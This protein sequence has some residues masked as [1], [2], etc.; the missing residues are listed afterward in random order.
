MWVTFR[1]MFNSNLN[2]GTYTAP[3]SYSSL[4]SACLIAIRSFVWTTMW[5]FHQPL[6]KGVSV[7]RFPVWVFIS[8][9]TW[10][11]LFF[12]KDNE[13]KSHLFLDVTVWRSFPCADCTCQRHD[14]FYLR[15]HLLTE[16]RPGCCL[17]TIRLACGFCFI[18]PL[19][20][21][22]EQSY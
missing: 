15:T 22:R 10:T 13:Q 18:R 6:L 20:G 1:P 2:F 5:S 9:Q 3:M 4:Y 19:H 7:K 11:S 8:W 14:Y 21:Q 17:N 12:T 16:M